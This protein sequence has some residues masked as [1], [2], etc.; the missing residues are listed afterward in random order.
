MCGRF[1][2]T[3]KLQKIIAQ[4]GVTAVNV[5]DVLPSYN[6]A[7]SKL[8]PV[9]TYAEKIQQR[10]IEL[11]KWGLVPGWAKD[12]K[13][14]NKM[15]NARAETVATKFRRNFAERRCLVPANGFF[16]WHVTTRQPYFIKVK[17]AD[18]LGFAGIWASWKTPAGDKLHSFSII[19][20]EPNELV[21]PI[22]NRMPVIIPAADY[23]AWLSP[24][25]SI[26]DAKE[27]LQ[28][29]PADNMEAWRVPKSVNNPRNDTPENLERL[30][31]L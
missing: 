10:Q 2:L 6:V 13:V 12:P 29:F 19:T 20:G 16:E 22:H 18:M 1:V 26:E 8:V 25:T 24:S 17:S 21:R 4:F 31:S 28:P 3:P 5:D 14:G 30:D 27:M 23:Q 9:V 7:P 15:I 11:M